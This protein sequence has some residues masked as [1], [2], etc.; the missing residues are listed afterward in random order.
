VTAAGARRTGHLGRVVAAGAGR[1]AAAGQADRAEPRD[2]RQMINGI[3]WRVR[4]GAPWRGIPERYGPWETAYCLFRSWQRDDT[5]SDVLAKLRARADAK[6]LITWDVSVDSTVARA[7]QH[8]A[9]ARQRGTISA[10]RRAQTTTSSPTITAWAGPRRAD[11]Q[12]AP[13]GRGRAAPAVAAGDRRPGRG[14]PA[15]RGRAR[16][17][18]RAPHG[19]GAPAVVAA[20][21]CSGDRGRRRCGTSCRA[22]RRGGADGVGVFSP[23]GEPAAGEQLTPAG[24]ALLAGV[25]R[26]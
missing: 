17:D 22:S 24:W 19:A 13:G 10:S 5:W 6:G 1:G 7:H 4:T 21:N 11:H 3:R 18:P 8:A 12:A 25:R 16:G 26:R 23:D 9:G 14:Q 15:V 2:R 20:G